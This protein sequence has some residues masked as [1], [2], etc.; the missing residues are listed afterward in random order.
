MTVE[1]ADIDV[2]MAAAI[3]ALSVIFIASLFVLIYICIR[4]RRGLQWE[5]LDKQK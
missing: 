3:G 1:R 4:H 2:L 5:R